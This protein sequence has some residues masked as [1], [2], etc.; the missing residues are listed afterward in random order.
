MEI[1]SSLW[2]GTPSSGPEGGAHRRLSA[3][4]RSP[5]SARA[6]VV[7]GILVLALALGGLAAVA[8]ATMAHTG[9]SHRGVAV[10]DHWIY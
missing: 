8:V 6:R 2:H 1:R 7:R 3:H 9:H 4:R 5:R 10:S